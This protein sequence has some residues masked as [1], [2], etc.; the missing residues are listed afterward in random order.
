MFRMLLLP[1]SVLP[2]YPSQSAGE[3]EAIVSLDAFWRKIVSSVINRR[4]HHP[5]QRL[6]KVLSQ[7]SERISD[8]QE[9]IGMVRL[10]Q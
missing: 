2:K 8:C 6:A 7:H 9:R 5:L 4:R 3:L 1:K 10:E